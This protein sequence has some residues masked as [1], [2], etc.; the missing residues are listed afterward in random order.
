MAKLK[1]C[2]FCGGNGAMLPCDGHGQPT[3]RRRETHYRVLCLKCKVRTNAY[4][5]EKGA[6]NAWNR[7]TDN[8]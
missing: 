6:F 1:P 2:P 5:T 8:V 3:I 7:R 4:L